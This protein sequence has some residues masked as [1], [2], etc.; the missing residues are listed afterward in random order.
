MFI[1]CCAAILILS[2]EHQ[3]IFV[4][5]DACSRWDRRLADPKG[6]PRENHQQNGGNVGLQDEEEHVPAQGEVQHQ[7]GV[8][9]WKE[10]RTAQVCAATTT[11]V[12]QR[13]DC[14][15][16]LSHT[17]PR[18]LWCGSSPRCT[19]PA[20]VCLNLSLNHCLWS[21]RTPRPAGCSPLRA[22]MNTVLKG[23]I[24][25]VLQASSAVYTHCTDGEI[26]GVDDEVTVIH[27]RLHG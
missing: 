8:L 22:N 6:D 16:Y 11:N 20:A 26:D 19:E 23:V 27:I 2:L 13:C 24:C 14:L 15:C 10:T 1:L 17:Q 12:Y 7:L 3:E 5:T 9:A 25:G 18:T 4:L 21:S